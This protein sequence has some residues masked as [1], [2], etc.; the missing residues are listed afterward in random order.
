[1]KGYA[2]LRRAGDNLKA[3]I[4][5]LVRSVGVTTGDLEPSSETVFTGP[6][7]HKAS[8]D[9]RLMLFGAALE[10]CFGRISLKD[11]EAAEKKKGK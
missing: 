3:A 2:K 8:Y 1:M 11:A 4:D 5:D 9:L 10:H 6:L 7:T